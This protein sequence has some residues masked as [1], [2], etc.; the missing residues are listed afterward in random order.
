MCNYNILLYDF[1]YL[2]KIFHMSTFI[3]IF[4]L[5]SHIILRDIVNNIIKN[6]CEIIG[7]NNNLK[8]QLR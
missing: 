4:G 8:V 5:I 3:S 6:H 1:F 2:Y 7:Y